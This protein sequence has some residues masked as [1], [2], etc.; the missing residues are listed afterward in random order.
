VP[1][2]VHDLR[3]AD[4]DPRAHAFDAAVARTVAEAVLDETLTDSINRNAL[5][6]ALD[7]ALIG[8]FGA[9]AVGWCWAA[10]E[11]GCGGPVRAG[12]GATTPSALAT[13][14]NANAR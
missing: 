14:S 9:W 3:W 5:E 6:A 7:R 13:S 12:A 2:A 10:S 11:P 8:A 1:I 4:V